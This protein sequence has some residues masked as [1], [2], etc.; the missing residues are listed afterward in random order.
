MIVHI[1]LYKIQEIKRVFPEKLYVCPV[2]K[3]F[4]YILAVP[5]K[6]LEG[7][8]VGWKENNRSV[9]A[10]RCLETTLIQI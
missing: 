5:L 10:S 3:T 9:I 6:G 2:I 8:C 4:W 1:S 7:S